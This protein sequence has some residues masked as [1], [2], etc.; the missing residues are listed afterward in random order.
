MDISLFHGFCPRFS[1]RADFLQLLGS[2]LRKRS[3]TQANGRSEP[4]PDRAHR[5]ERVENAAVATVKQCR[6]NRQRK[7]IHPPLDRRH[8]KIGSHFIKPV[9]FDRETCLVFFFLFLLLFFF[10]SHG[11]SETVETSTGALA[12][13][14]GPV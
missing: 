11:Y 5:R 7:T 1:A 3:T 2:G 13:G 9:R 4:T 14:Q 8:Y 12:C 6:E 10:Y